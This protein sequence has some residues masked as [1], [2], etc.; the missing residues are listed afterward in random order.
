[1]N[2]IEEKVDQKVREFEEK[3]NLFGP[4]N[5]PHCNNMRYG[6]EFSGIAPYI[7]QA[8]QE[9]YTQ[10]KLET[11]GQVAEVVRQENYIL[12]EWYASTERPQAITCFDASQRNIQTRNTILSHI[13]S[14]KEPLINI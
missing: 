10:G 13:S 11:L 6:G 9:V 2:T 3:F 5:P 4:C 12:E 7:R 1:M 14:L 8:L